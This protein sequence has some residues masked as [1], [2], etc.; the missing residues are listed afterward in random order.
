M[1]RRGQDRFRRFLPGVRGGRGLILLL[2]IVLGI[3]LLTGFYRVEPDEQ[4]VVL[5][6]GEWPRPPSRA[7][8]IICPGPSRRFSCPR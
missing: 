1:L 8:T 5:R 4:G 2:I 6:W 7:S 3:W